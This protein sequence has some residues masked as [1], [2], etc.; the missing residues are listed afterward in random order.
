MKRVRVW[1][2]V[3]AVMYGA[4]G[5]AESKTAVDASPSP[6]DVEE[7]VDGLAAV[8]VGATDT[9]SGE[10]AADGPA[11][12]DATGSELPPGPL[13]NPPGRHE[14]TLVVGGLTRE[15]IVYVPEAA[16]KER[17]PVVF[18]LHGT[19]GNGEQFFNVSGWV[20][21][22][23]AEGF[24]VLFPSALRHCFF[25]DEDGDGDFD[26][27]GERKVT[28]KWA[29]GGLGDPEV[30]PLCDE[31]DLKMLPPAQRAQVDHPLADDLAFFDA[32]LAMLEERYVTDPKAVYV[33]GFSNGAQ[34]AARLAVE[35]AHT[36][37]AAHAAAGTLAVEGQATRPISVV[38]S[39]GS[40]DDRF[41][42]P[43]GLAELPLG[44]DELT[45]L[46]LFRYMVSSFLV[47]LELTDDYSYQ[48]IPIGDARVARLVFSTS[49]TGADNRL[50]VAVIEGLEHKYPNGNNHVVSSA[51]LLWAFM[52]QHRL[53]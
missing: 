44:E 41:T 3:C 35:R 1:V 30:M 50:E 49:L 39:V 7:V 22:A 18:M 13:E 17:V 19:S 45:S 10:E 6:A 14:E 37:A 23:D 42:V 32:M 52:A 5:A 38:W 20:Q 21:K 36:I 34:M 43:M 27:P 48:L 11:E 16:R 8:D 29:S 24:V 28:T 46:P 25:E 40:L 53:P 31:D 15:V 9:V 26:G 51:N 33:S 2:M 47:A 4:C 12:V